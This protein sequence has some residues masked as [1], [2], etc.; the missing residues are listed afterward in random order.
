MGQLAG[1]VTPFYCVIYVYKETESSKKNL[2]LFVKNGLQNNEDIFY[3]FAINGEN[4]TVPIPELA[5]VEVIRR[6]NVGHDFGAW[7]ECLD[8]LGSKDLKFDYYIFMNDTVA[9]PFLPRY[10]N[11]GK[12]Y[13]MF[14]SL[15]SSSA[16]LSGLSINSD[17]WGLG[18]SNMRHV[19]SMMFCTDHIG[20]GI[21]QASIFTLAPEEFQAVY[22][23]SR[24]EFIAR[25]EIG[26]SQRI[27]EQ[28]YEIA[29]LFIPD[30]LS[31]DMGDIWHN[32]KY[33]N[34]TVNPFETMFIKANR[35]SSPVV[36]L[37]T[38]YSMEA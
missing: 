8:V 11:K 5:N 13:E 6:E 28:G 3:V 25:F 26:M 20:L 23:N 22:E 10:I 12:W 14:C 33:F 37:Y 35:V 38:E 36:D 32:G 19:Q 1:H 2:Q 24:K 16:K 17:P 21:L 31:I 34:S 4:L 30:A 27:L 9:G 29:A 7:K 15:I 18:T